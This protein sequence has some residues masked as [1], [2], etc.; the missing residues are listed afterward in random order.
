MRQQ[1]NCQP[2]V[3]FARRLRFSPETLLG[4]G[5]CH[6]NVILAQWASQTKK[7]TIKSSA[8]VVHPGKRADALILGFT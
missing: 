3:P 6:I 7:K 1:P 8:H 5:P 4:F 2:A